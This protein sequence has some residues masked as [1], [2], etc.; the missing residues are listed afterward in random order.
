M[1]AMLLGTQKGGVFFSWAPQKK[2]LNKDN[3]FKLDPVLSSDTM[4]NELVL[5]LGGGRPI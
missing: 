2:S 3:I 1:L 4:G 5:V